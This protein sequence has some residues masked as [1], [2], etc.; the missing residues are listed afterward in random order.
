MMYGDKKTK[1]KKQK[2]TSEKILRLLYMPI[3]IMI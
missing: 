1:K 2:N 3:T